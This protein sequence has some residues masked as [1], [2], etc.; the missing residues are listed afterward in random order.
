MKETLA[1]V[2]RFN[3]LADSPA[4]LSLLLRDSGLDLSELAAAKEPTLALC[5]DY[6]ADNSLPEIIREVGALTY[7]ILIETAH[8]AG[9]GIDLR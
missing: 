4:K 3:P 1:R 6:D 7:R 2:Q 8:I 9:I 5:L